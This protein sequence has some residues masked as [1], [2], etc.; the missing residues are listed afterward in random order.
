MHQERTISMKKRILL[1]GGIVLTVFI[2][3]NIAWFIWRDVSYSNYT[4][5][6]SPTSFSNFI[7]PKY[8][9]IDEDG[10][11]FYVKYPDYL[12]L[13]G[14]I[15]VGMPTENN[16][17]FTDTLIIWPLLDGEYDIGALLY[18]DSGSYQ[19]YIDAQ[20]NALNNADNEVIKR[21][22]E[23]INILLK[24]AGDLWDIN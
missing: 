14:N 5:N 20:G 23:N 13:T 11:Q 15:N 17:L 4:K 10:F 8:H 19:I 1:I 21:H 16:N 2:L 9:L 24:K 3:I 12:S 6:M 7:V 22:Q 18:D